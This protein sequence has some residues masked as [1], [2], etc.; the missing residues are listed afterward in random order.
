VALGAK[1]LASGRER[2]GVP[3]FKIR[4]ASMRDVGILVEHRHRMFEEMISPTVEESRL[5]DEAYEAWAKDMMRRKLLHVYIAET[6]DGRTAASGGVWLREMQPSPGHPHGMVPY[7][8]SVYTRPEFRRKG[9]A[10]M[11]VEEAMEWGRKKGYYKMVLHASLTGRKVYSQLGWKRTW[12]MEFRYDE[13][14][15]GVRR[16]APR[17]SK[18]SR[19]AR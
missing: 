12:E 8:L 13:R 17:S 16:A 1:V 19:P 6:R 10:S 9:L 18:P 14:P 2:A 5:H 11:I 15:A 7:V 3:E 4:R